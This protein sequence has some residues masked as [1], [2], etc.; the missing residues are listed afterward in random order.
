[1]LKK[2]KCLTCVH[3]KYNPITPIWLNFLKLEQKTSKYKT[4]ENVTFRTINN[5]NVCVK[6]MGI[7][8]C[9]CIVGFFNY[10]LEIVLSI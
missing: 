7:N 1:M 2:N 10:Y 5:V 9:H 8:A 6:V 3:A 4:Y